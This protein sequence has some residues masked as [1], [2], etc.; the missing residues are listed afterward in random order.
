MY[1][2]IYDLYIFIHSAK[3]GKAK[4]DSCS[5]SYPLI[6]INYVNCSL[7]VEPLILLL[8]MSTGGKTCEMHLIG[9]GFLAPWANYQTLESGLHWVVWS[10][11]F[12]LLGICSCRTECR[13][14]SV[15]LF[16][17]YFIIIII[18]KNSFPILTLNLAI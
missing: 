3:L 9:S 13:G 2:T 14:P 7:Q 6:F 17:F 8:F 1:N 16:V 4:V 11:C 12:H 15:R 18:F 5:F 10:L